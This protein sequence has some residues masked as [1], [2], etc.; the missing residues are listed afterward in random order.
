MP[1]SSRAVIRAVWTLHDRTTPTTVE[2]IA[3][4]LQTPESDVKRELR[5]LKASR[6]VDVRTRK[7][8]RVWLPWAEVH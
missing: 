4:Y 7:G 1:V 5:E 3:K 6:L 2:A 8:E